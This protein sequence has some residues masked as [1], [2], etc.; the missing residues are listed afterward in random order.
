MNGEKRAIIALNQ[1]L[2]IVHLYPY[3]RSQTKHRVY[4]FGVG[5]AKIL[6]GLSADIKKAYN[7]VS[8]YK[9][10]MKIQAD[11]PSNRNDSKYNLILFLGSPLIIHVQF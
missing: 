2:S 11:T 6:L 7:I 4:G 5:R 1:N 3:F 8:K 9:L 10:D